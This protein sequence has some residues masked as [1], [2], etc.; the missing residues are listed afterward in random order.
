MILMDKD[1]YKNISFGDVVFYFNDTHEVRE[2]NILMYACVHEL[3]KIYD[4]GERCL[5]NEHI[6]R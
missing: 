2:G 3:Q 1:Y 4:D 5:N 6:N